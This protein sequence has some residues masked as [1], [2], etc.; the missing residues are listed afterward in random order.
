[1][2]LK[3]GLAQFL[4]S[5]CPCSVGSAVAFRMAKSAAAALLDELM[6]RNRNAAPHEQNNEVKWEDPEVKL[7]DPLGN[8]FFPH[9][10]FVN[11]DAR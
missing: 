10:L 5:F 8:N 7:N 3:V 11:C 1:M 2:S 6:G 4:I 9:Y